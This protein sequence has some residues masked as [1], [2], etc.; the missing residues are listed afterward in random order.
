MGSNSKGHNEGH[1]EAMAWVRAP[2]G[3]KDSKLSATKTRA[4][5]A[6]LIGDAASV[7]LLLSLIMLG[8]TVSPLHVL[9]PAVLVVLVA[10]AR[11]SIVQRRQAAIFTTILLV[12][13]ISFADFAFQITATFVQLF[14]LGLT[15]VLAGIVYG[16][17]KALF[18]LATVVL[19][20]LFFGFTHESPPHT[21]FSNI[22][23]WAVTSALLVS[24]TVTSLFFGRKNRADIGQAIGAGVYT[25]E[26]LQ[27]A[28][29]RLSA[30]ADSPQ[31]NR[32]NGFDLDVTSYDVQKLLTNWVDASRLSNRSID[33]S[34]FA[35]EIATPM[36]TAFSMSEVFEERL[37]ALNRRLDAG[38]IAASQ[39]LIANMSDMCGMIQRNIRSTSNLV[40]TYTNDGAHVSQDTF[41]LRTVVE[42]M[43]GALLKVLQRDDI[44]LA[45]DI[46]DSIRVSGS[47]E[48]FGQI[49]AYLV[50]IAVER[51]FSPGGL[52]QGQS[53]RVSLAPHDQPG[54]DVSWQI[55][56]EDN[57]QGWNPSN[58][59]SPDG[60]VGVG[61]AM[62]SAV[63]RKMGGDI[64]ISTDKRSTGAAFT[65]LIPKTAHA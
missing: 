33:F 21:Q 41:A 10:F 32:G 5:A 53:I 13:C 34:Q 36:S 42:S 20:L 25:K 16:E 12:G 62:A 38:E 18:L 1:I 2:L 43:A 55:L 8:K 35:H 63:A 45:V 19:L 14:G 58:Q 17:R 28:K 22:E 30:Q 7:L 60:I 64:T 65:I 3:G 51:G 46:P 49:I 23:Q 47:A 48:R 39:K 6:C 57:G 29:N 24:M 40:Q 9:I 52:R 61:L 59:G 4:R 54:S 26:L 31:P 44:S 37:T 56:Y 50:S 11:I 15:I 27:E